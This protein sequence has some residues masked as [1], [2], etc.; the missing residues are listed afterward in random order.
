MSKFRFDRNSLVDTL[1]LKV[2]RSL[3]RELI[4]H[5]LDHVTYYLV[6]SA[7]DLNGF[8]NNGEANYKIMKCFEH[9]SFRLES[10]MV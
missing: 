1:D 10:T 4:G 3:G 8:G 6:L 7:A 9:N 2:P 5:D